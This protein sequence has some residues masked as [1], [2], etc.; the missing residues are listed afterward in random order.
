[1]VRR[2]RN[3][4]R[5]WF[6]RIRLK[7]RRSRRI[8]RFKAGLAQARFIHFVAISSFILVIL[9]SITTAAVFA[10]Y[11]RDLPNPDQVVRRDG[12]STKIY[13]RNGELLY[14]VFGDENRIPV[15]INDIPD[16]LKYATVSIEDK[17]LYTHEGLV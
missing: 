2:R 10:W 6:Y 11:S 3:I 16:S 12:F 14:D 17:D 8:A 5:S 4:R 13:D 9:G 1:M 15:K 7:L